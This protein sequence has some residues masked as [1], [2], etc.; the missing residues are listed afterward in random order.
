MPR[1]YS[2]GTGCN[3]LRFT[4]LAH[5]LPGLERSKTMNRYTYYRVIQG[6]YGYGWCDEDHHETNSTYCFLNRD[7][8][9][10]FKENLRLYRENGGGMYRVIKRREIRA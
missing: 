7:A 6:N 3:T 9:S 8:R 10:A 1:H 4:V 2:G 5:T